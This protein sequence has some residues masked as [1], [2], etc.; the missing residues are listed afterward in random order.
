[1][2]RYV[3]LFLAAVLFA[4]AAALCMEHAPQEDPGRQME[5]RNIELEMQRQEAKAQF[6][7][8]MANLELQQRRMELERQG[9]AGPHRAILPPK[10][11]DGGHPLLLLICVVHILTS[12]WVYMDIRERNRGSGLWV[13]ITLLAGLLGALVYAVVRL[14]DDGKNNGRKKA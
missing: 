14:G 6:E 5:L 1:M 12:V 13:V 11:K 4:P 10:P 3:T 9:Q 8:E 2:K 7:R